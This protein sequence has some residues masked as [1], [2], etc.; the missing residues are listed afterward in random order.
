MKIRIFHFPQVLFLFV[1]VA[2]ALAYTVFIRTPNE[3]DAGDTKEKKEVP[4]K[5]S[6]TSLPADET[7][8]AV[9]APGYWRYALPEGGEIVV[10][11]QKTGAVLRWQ[12]H[13]R[14]WVENAPTPFAI[15]LVDGT[16][17]E[18]VVDGV[19]D[20][21]AGSVTVR[22][23]VG[24]F[25]ARVTYTLNPEGTALRVALKLD[26]SAGIEEWTC[27]FPLALERHKKVFFQ[28]DHYLPWESR[29]TYA[30]H[31]STSATLLASP[32]FNEWRWFVAEQLSPDAFRIW[33]SESDTTSPL[34]MQ[35]GKRMPPY[36]QVFDERGGVTIEYPQM[37][38]GGRRALR[39][40]AKN[41]GT[42]LVTIQ[43]PQPERASGTP[44]L[45]EEQVIHLYASPS[46]ESLKEKREAINAAFTPS[47]P[48]ETELME[49]L[50][51]RETP[52]ANG[53]QYVTGGL[54]FAQGALRDA[55]VVS[56]QVAGVPVPVQA[57]PLG[58]WPD[59]S[60]KWVLLTFPLTNA[61]ASEDAPAP[62]VTLRTG[63][64]LP[65]VT[66]VTASPAP[67]QQVEARALP[68]GQVEVRNGPMVLRFNR[69]KEWLDGS[70]N[71]TPLFTAPPKAYVRFR[72]NVE[73]H[74]PFALRLQGGV[75]R[76]EILDVE[77]AQLEEQ[78][79]LR[80]VVRLE[81][82]VAD[83]E[84]TRII[85]RV[86]LHAGRPEIL[87]TH[88]AEFR[89]KDPRTTFLTGMG[90]EFPVAGLSAAERGIVQE[91]HDF[92]W[93]YGNIQPN[94]GGWLSA[95]LE[96]GTRFS[97]GIRHAAQMAP[98]AMTQRGNVIS[99]EL[100]PE[101]V[102]P[103][104][105]RRYSNRG[106][107]AQGEAVEDSA[108]WVA[109]QY[110]PHAPFAGIS[111]THELALGF[112]PASQAP[113]LNSLAADFESP[114]LLYPGWESVLEAGVLLPASSS[115]G[116]PKVWENRDHLARFWLYHQKLHHWY[117]FWNFGDF[118]HRFRDGYGWVTTPEKLAA[119]LADPQRQLPA[120]APR[121]Q[122]YKPAND[123]A[124]DNGRWGWSNSEGLSNLFLQQEYLRTGNRALYFAAEAMARY[125]RDVVIRHEAPLL[126]RGTRHGVQPWS[127][128]NHEERQTTTTEFRTH[129]FL[130]GDARTREV[131]DGLYERYYSRSPVSNEAAHSGR[132]GGLLFH[133]EMTG[134][135]E[136]AD[137]LRRY[138][139]AFIAPDGAG[140]YLAPHLQFPG[141][142]TT[143]PAQSL[144]A[145]RMF[146]AC[147]GALHNMLEYQ[148]TFQDEALKEG[149]LA[150]A[151]D[152][153]GRPPDSFEAI[154]LLPFVAFAAQN[155]PDPRPFKRYLLTALR[156][157]RAWPALYQSV[158]ANPRHWSGPTAFLHNNMPGVFFWANWIP[159]I[160]GS[161]T[162]D[163]I[164]SKDIEARASALE[165][166]GGPEQKPTEPWLQK[167]YDALINANGTYTPPTP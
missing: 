122:D 38:E 105:V 125:C 145:E 69:G 127:D 26:A 142:Q 44:S 121:I 37:A 167:D 159:Y 163:T 62:R 23:H 162:H 109:E 61:K 85:L 112:W 71:E 140:L 111:R 24:S 98:K 161:F 17:A 128:G 154:F 100:W 40:D 147:Y 27:A 66:G 72:R 120:D 80:A 39:V 160:T 124:D 68:D 93:T 113:E 130:S 115:D 51:L 31:L 74:E 48:V 156:S 2:A 116:W 18:F 153:I 41:H 47:A 110:Y 20:N 114:P 3:V 146:F 53:I 88:T 36:A 55:S 149:L 158:T 65:V 42:A 131:I 104:D 19:E 90:L 139:A 78:G 123:W 14:V 94:P 15:T 136:E 6:E 83:G 9:H 73:T 95:S 49:P 118:R 89:F 60:L 119:A 108:E 91:S 64:A 133:Q 13:G 84:A 82:K 45:H 164:W 117:G 107:L 126:G 135:P 50:W 137:Q 21:I 54:P 35:E 157:D 52:L 106:H 75:E 76:E 143:G 165:E 5:A 87:F 92:Q 30:F 144:N 151:R 103:M 70:L 25:P 43:A 132:W 148:R 81:G 10:D 57:R 4:M 129:Y 56:A 7:K 86:T 155:A 67:A 97:G 166:R 46:E 33:K 138:A 32:D 134:S 11:T 150:M 63:G 79:P 99:Y 96:N 8:E 22:G 59:G 1:I 77:S 152:V 141:P 101:D 28:G 34:V 102:S 58:F 12:S 16:R 29:F